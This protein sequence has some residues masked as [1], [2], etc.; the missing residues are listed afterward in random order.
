MTR[1]E[2]VQGYYDGMNKKDLG[3]ISK[4]FHENIHMRGPFLEKKDKPTAL[5]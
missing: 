4:Y 2:A 5:E 3:T 1:L